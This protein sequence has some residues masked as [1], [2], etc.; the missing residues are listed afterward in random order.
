MQPMDIYIANVPFDDKNSNKIR[1]ALVV[2]VKDQ[3]V[4]VFKIT[5]KFKNKSQFVKGFYYPIEEWKEAGLRKKSYVDTHKTYNLPE[6]MVF[7]KKPIGKLTDQD[8][9][10]LFKFSNNWKQKQG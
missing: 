3:R 7:S 9:I 10:N 2:K 1:P 4:N 6:A 5:S 8:V